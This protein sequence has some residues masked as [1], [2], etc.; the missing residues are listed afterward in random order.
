MNDLSVRGI[1]RRY[2]VEPRIAFFG[3]DDPAIVGDPKNISI[4]KDIMGSGTGSL[5]SFLQP[6]AFTVSVLPVGTRTSVTISWGQR[7]SSR[8]GHTST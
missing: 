2:L 5:K 4:A 1:Y 7:V 3:T 6:L 8:H